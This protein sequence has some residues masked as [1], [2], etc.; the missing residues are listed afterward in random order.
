MSSYR[1]EGQIVRDALEDVHHLRIKAIEVLGGSQPELVIVEGG[2]MGG[3]IATLLA[4][5]FPHL[6]SGCVAIGAALLLKENIPNPPKLSYN[7]QIPIIF[8]TNTSVFVFR[9]ISADT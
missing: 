8:L 1:R 3:F 5:N 7:P 2:S 6:Y 9:V 4:E